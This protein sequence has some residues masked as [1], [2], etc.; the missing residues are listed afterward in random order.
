MVVGMAKARSTRVAFTGAIMAG[1]IA[2]AAGA[3]TIATAA[4]VADP[5]CPGHKQIVW[6]DHTPQ[7]TAD[8]ASMTWRATTLTTHGWSLG[9]FTAQVLWVGTDNQ[10]SADA[11]VETGITEGFD[12]LNVFTFYSA[13]GTLSGGYNEVRYSGAPTPVVGTAY[14]FRGYS[15]PTPGTPVYRTEV[16]AGGTSYYVT[17]SGHA[18]NTVNYSGGYEA[19]GPYPCDSRVDATY[20]YNN[21]FRRKSD[22]V[23]VTI[24]NGSRTDLS[25]QGTIGWC[26]QPTTF[27]HWM[28]S[29]A[30]TSVCP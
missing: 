23:N 26:A 9:G 8:G 3:P 20:M 15:V 24:N 11:W 25:T 7:A 2:L 4:H 13:H 17:W 19:D 27:R 22:G 10:D 16:R 5:L 14:I 18:T 28:H 6:T 12:G 1:I 29:Q 21:T 30:S